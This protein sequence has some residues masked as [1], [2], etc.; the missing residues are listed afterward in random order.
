MKLRFRGQQIVNVLL[1]TSIVL[2]LTLLL[3]S[4]SYGEKKKIYP[5]LVRAAIEKAHYEGSI[6]DRNI[7][8][9][10]SYEV[11][12]SG[13][14]EVS[15]PFFSKGVVFLSTDLA[16]RNGVF[17]P[18]RKGGMRLILFNP[19]KISFHV[20]FISP[21]KSTDGWNLL[22]LT[23][24]QSV[25]T[26]MNI[27]LPCKGY[28][29]RRL[30]SFA[31]EQIE[32]KEDTILRIAVGMERE[33][34]LSYKKEETLPQVNC[35]FH[36]ADTI[37]VSLEGVRRNVELS[38]TPISGQ[39][40]ALNILL[41]DG[42]KIT[43]ISSDIPHIWEQD[44]N[45][46]RINLIK[47]CEK[48]FTMHLTTNISKIQ[49]D[50]I[51]SIHSLKIEK[52]RRFG[53]IL[54]L[55]VDKNLSAKVIKL[56]GLKKFG[57]V[58][59]GVSDAYM[60]S[61]G[62]RIKLGIYP[63]ESGITSETYQRFLIQEKEMRL[64]LNSK[65]E[66]EGLPVYNLKFYVPP[67]Y[68][69]LELTSRGLTDWACEDNHL[70]L[71]YSGGFIG[72]NTINLIGEKKLEGLAPE[73]L[74][75]EG[76][77]FPPHIKDKGIVRIETKLPLQLRPKDLHLLIETVLPE[78]RIV[79][80]GTVT[81]S[82]SYRK[83]DWSLV[84]ERE[85][86]TP[87][88]SAKVNTRI[89]LRRDSLEGESNI[90]FDISDAGMKEI[91]FSLTGEVEGVELKGNH[92]KSIQ[93]PAAGEKATEW[94]VILEKHILG[95][96][97]LIVKYKQ[98]ISP[99]TQTAALPVLILKDVETIRG[100]VEI[101]PASSLEVKPE[102]AGNLEE[103]GQLTY[104]YYRQPYSLNMKLK[105]LD[106]TGV[107]QTVVEKACI[108][109]VVS[110]TGEIMTEAIISLKNTL[111]QYLKVSLPEEAVLW[112]VKVDGRSVRPGIYED[113]YLIPL[114]GRSARFRSIPIKLIYAESSQM[115]LHRFPSHL[116][117]TSPSFEIP[118]KS[119]DWILYLPHTA[120]R[121]KFKTNMEKSTSVKI[122][123]SRREIQLAR[124]DTHQGVLRVGTDI[125]T[126]LHI[127]PLTIDIPRVGKPYYFYRAI[128]TPAQGPLYIE[129]S[130]RKEV[131]YLKIII[132]LLALAA[133]CVIARRKQKK[134]VVQP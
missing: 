32:K 4:S 97:Q 44:K 31:L 67:E 14:G 128:L 106:Q 116:K 59:D 41:N 74:K 131:K 118:S 33:I 94:K 8:F 43:S 48:N 18:D 110:S 58:L 19:G 119:M 125:K 112:Q 12:V 91:G 90:D 98:Y 2:S 6:K 88:I 120:G 130:L 9:T 50:A 105:F 69:I 28:K 66:V 64:I 95:S 81:I 86:L 27:K 57:E 53:G 122:Q 77:K 23:L 75:I 38:C 7:L 123:K 26:G 46:L 126:K 133:L 72:R 5:P 55:R 132:S 107:L 87:S 100:K 129:I 51:T 104:S 108:T 92:I 113:G 111:N 42:E 37:E 115:S 35:E 82:Y 63:Q 103:T 45:L 30:S 124:Y 70:T 25:I 101:K 17:L 29:V 49:M 3:P 60:F 102:L 47:P 36:L 73:D 39:A 127:P 68:K 24:P 61:E 76:I 15:L 84:L 40:A 80:D 114:G 21:L 117:I 62:Y 52:A 22:R 121:V 56:K 1:L 54:R 78:G 85:L 20:N 83:S 65:L 93:E 16:S 89:S 134:P 79:G 13:K 11:K 34:V 96:Y 109:S 71:K 99:E 10:A